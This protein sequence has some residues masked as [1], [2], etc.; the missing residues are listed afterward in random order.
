MLK[1]GLA[2]RGIVQ[3]QLGSGRPDRARQRAGH[4]RPRLALGRAGRAARADAV[5]LQDH[6]LRRRA[7]GALSTRSTNWPEKVRLMQANWIGRS[8]G[9][10]IRWALRHDD[11]RRRRGWTELEVYTTRARHAVRRLVHG[12]CRRSSA[13][14]RPRPRK[15]PRS[16]PFCDECRRMGTSVADIEAAEKRGFDTGIRA[17]HPFD[18]GLDSCRSTSPTSC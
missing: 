4:R 8:E 14:P 12:G 15:N 1:K 17:I 6:R 3:G 9:L 11:G 2:Y 13:A 16:Q 10:L 7:A 5:V 18:P